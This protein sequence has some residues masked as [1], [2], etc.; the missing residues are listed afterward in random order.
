MGN[1]LLT[2]VLLHLN[3]SSEHSVDPDQVA[4]EEAS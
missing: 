2:L 3:I 4:S 1:A